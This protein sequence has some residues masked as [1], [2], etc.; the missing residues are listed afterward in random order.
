MPAVDSFNAKRR[1]LRAENA[2]RNLAFSAL[3]KVI[4][5]KHN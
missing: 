1:N 3:I 5:V 4:N 2:H